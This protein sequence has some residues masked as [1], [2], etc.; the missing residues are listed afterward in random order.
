MFPINHASVNIGLTVRADLYRSNN[1][2][3]KKLL[4]GFMN[5]IEQEGRLSPE[6]KISRIASWPLHLA[7][8]GNQ[9][10]IFDGALLIGDAAAFI[11]PFI[12][13]GIHNALISAQIAGD[14]IDEGFQ[15]GDLSIHQLKQYDQLCREKFGSVFRRSL[16]LQKAMLY[17]PGLLDGLAWIVDR[18]KSFWSPLFSR[19]SDNFHFEIA[20]SPI[21]MVFEEI[22]S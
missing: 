4:S 20:E 19:Y 16:L 5:V 12:G 3:L 9:Q 17:T 13:E 6:F 7:V 10:L 18:K 8:S 2:D 15:K 11:D 22:K 14:V 1:W 21:R